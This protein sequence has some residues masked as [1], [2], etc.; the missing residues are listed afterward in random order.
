MME[1]Q[2]KKKKA[3]MFCNIPAKYERAERF[4][5]HLLCIYLPKHFISSDIK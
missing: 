3:T 5:Y 4:Y 2:K 1:K